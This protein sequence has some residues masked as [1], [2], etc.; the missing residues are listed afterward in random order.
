M[1]QIPFFIKVAREGLG[2]ASAG[3]PIGLEISRIELKPNGDEGGWETTVE[4]AEGKRGIRVALS[5][6]GDVEY[7]E[8][9]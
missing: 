6:T 3:M 8:E 5:A 7:V 9:Q 1:T 4:W 2:A